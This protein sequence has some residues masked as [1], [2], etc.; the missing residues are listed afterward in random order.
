[1]VRGIRT[2]KCP[3]CGH[4]FK[5]FDIEWKCT[6]ATAPVQ[7]PKCGGWTEVEW[8]W[9]MTWPDNLIKLFTKK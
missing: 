2:F 6:V 5:A 8:P 1:M 4:E 7:C 9:T 3:H